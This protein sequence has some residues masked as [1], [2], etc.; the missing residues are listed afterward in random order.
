MQTLALFLREQLPSGLIYDDAAQLCLRLHCVNDGV[1]LALL[2]HT[3]LPA[4]ADVFAELARAGWIREQDSPMR[5]LYGARLH[6]VTD[7]GHW[8]E[9]IA[10]IYKKGGV[11]DAT[12]GEALALRVGFRTER[13]CDDPPA[14]EQERAHGRE[15]E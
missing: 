8:V 10:S 15:P 6:E 12:R 9:V 13:V 1:P 5:T 14:A 11:V 3:A 2:A 4:L 7:R